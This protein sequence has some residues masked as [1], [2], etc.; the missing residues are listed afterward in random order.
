MSY[1]LTNSTAVTRSS[2]VENFP[3]EIMNNTP[4]RRKADLITS[5]SAPPDLDELRS[6]EAVAKTAYDALGAEVSALEQRFNQPL[7]ADTRETLK[8]VRGKLSDLQADLAIAKRG[9]ET[10]AA[11]RATAET[12]ALVAEDRARRQELE[13][14]RDKAAHTVPAIYKRL[15]DEL[16]AIV[17]D[18]YQLDTEIEAYNKSLPRGLDGQRMPGVEVISTFEQIVRW[19]SEEIGRQPFYPRP[20]AD[21]F[22]IPALKRGDPD[23]RVSGTAAPLGIWI[24]ANGRPRL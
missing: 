16:L 13:A 9:Y 14:R 17:S 1:T 7:A 21:V 23:Y 19:P 18:V 8:Q 24:D 6:K 12:N 4:P 5:S 22:E 2:N 15:A 10:A 3:G 20:L 11:A